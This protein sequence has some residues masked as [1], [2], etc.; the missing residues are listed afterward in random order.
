MARSSIL[1]LVFVLAISPLCHSDFDY[2]D[3][4]STIDLNF[5]GGATSAGDRIR[6]APATLNTSGAVWHAIAQDVDGGFVT[7][8]T[9]QMSSVSGADG[10]AFVIQGISGNEIGCLGGNPCGSST[11]HMGSALGYEGIPSVAVELDSYNNGNVGDPNGNHTSIH[12]MGTAPNDADEA[13]AS[14]GSGL[15][16]GTN[17][18][19]GQSIVVRITYV[20]GM[21]EVFVQDLMTPRVSVSLDLAATLGAGPKWVGFTASTGGLVQ[22]HDVLDWSLTTMPSTGSEFIRGECN[23][24]GSVNLADAVFLLSF[25]F[26]GVG[27]PPALPCEDACDADDMGSIN[28]ADVITLLGSQF[29]M[30]PTPLPGPSTCGVD[31]TGGDVSDCAG[32]G[33]CP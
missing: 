12:T 31:P 8:F 27:G 10:M 7:E 16:P 15:I 5:V 11:M 22:D 4:V 33:G 13:M 18:N 24:D 21:M 1:S 25:L 6:I 3:F 17:L 26:P 2:P 29:G 20:P 30:P 23:N 19:S 9:F 28:L 32:F 14:I